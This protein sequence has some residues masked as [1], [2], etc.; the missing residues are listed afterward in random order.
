[1]ERA[2]NAR[3]SPGVILGEA[4]FGSVYALALLPPVYITLSRQHALIAAVPASV[5][6]LI[7]VSAAGIVATYGL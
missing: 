3:S 7:L 6:Y 5:W 4:L 1:M 2:M